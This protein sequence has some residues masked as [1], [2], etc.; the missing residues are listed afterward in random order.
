MAPWSCST[1]QGRGPRD[2]TSSRSWFI[3][4]SCF[5]A[6]LLCVWQDK[7]TGDAS[8]MTTGKPLG[9]SS[10]AATKWTLPSHRAL[11]VITGDVALDIEPRPKWPR[12]SRSAR[13][14]PTAAMAL[15]KLTAMKSRSMQA[16]GRHGHGQGPGDEEPQRKDDHDLSRQAPA[17]M[18]HVHGSRA[19]RASRSTAGKSPWTGQGR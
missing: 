2:G 3:E 10:T 6:A 1:G 13:C 16:H 11:A 8:K 18:T 14:R 15:G 12:A 9:T 7:P 4:T 5:P 17:A 19:F